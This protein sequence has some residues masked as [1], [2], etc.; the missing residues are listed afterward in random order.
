MKEVANIMEEVKEIGY[1]E[2]GMGPRF[3]GVVV[4]RKKRKAKTVK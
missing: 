2:N 1:E 4:E 3:D